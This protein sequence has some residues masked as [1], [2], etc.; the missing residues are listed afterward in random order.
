MWAPGQQ[1]DRFRL[2]KILGQGGFGITFLAK[3]EHGDP[4]VIKILK[5]DLSNFANQQANFRDEALNLLLCKHP[6][7]VKMLG[8]AE[9]KGVVGIVMEFIEGDTLGSV[10]RCRPMGRMHEVEALCNVHEVAG[11]LGEVHKRGLVHRDVNPSN[12]MIQKQ[13]GSAKLIDLGLAKKYSVDDQASVSAKGTGNYMALEQYERINDSLQYDRTARPHTDIYG[14]AATL[15]HMVVGEAPLFS[16][17][18]RL[19]TQ[20]QEQ[21]I[22]QHMWDNLD[23]AG[24]SERTKEAIMWGMKVLPIDRPQTVEDFLAAMPS[25]NNLILSPMQP[26]II[27]SPDEQLIEIIDAKPLP[28]IPPLVII[29]DPDKLPKNVKGSEFDE[30][31]LEWVRPTSKN[32]LLKWLL[33]GILSVVI[34][35]PIVHNGYT[36]FLYSH[37]YN[38]GIDRREKQ[39][40]LESLD[41]FNQAIEI[42]PINV[43]AYL[44]RAYLRINK[45]RD[46]QGA[47]DDYNQAIKNNPYNAI[48][49]TNR[50]ILKNDQ[51]S[52]RDGALNDY[53]RAIE[54]D[55]EY[56]PAYNA[57]CICLTPPGL[58][59]RSIFYEVF[60]TCYDEAIKV[61]PDHAPTY[62]SRGILKAKVRDIKGA[63]EDYNK[64]IE[65]N[66][67]YAEAYNAVGILAESDN[68][69]N[70]SLQHYDKAIEI[71]PEYA[72]AYA[73]RG[74]V[75][76]SKF[77]NIVSGIQDLRQAAKLYEKQGE[78]KKLKDI[79]S[80]LQKIEAK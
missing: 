3:D 5:S 66:R 22:D 45:L 12:I 67:A 61:N 40:Y 35:F 80:Q 27:N 4:C 20:Q 48:T 64:A 24:V 16:A 28:P 33:V 49:Y 15:Y 74:N 60:L 41:F 36:I 56:A 34:G 79:N 47:L 53:N 13:T 19:V 72:D 43:N 77:K 9:D 8:L 78:Q 52:D 26:V 70:S 76:Y 71:N 23:K 32:T 68:N 65:I 75:K 51:L 58:T 30:L 46:Y 17:Q 73:F 50:G 29:D 7:I 59:T 6:N 39:S 38:Q 18:G 62:L 69:I 44:E 37:Y 55:K 1:V 54:I 31:A 14:L 10:I 57:R 11:A 21:S 42:D 63:S 2:E 25:L